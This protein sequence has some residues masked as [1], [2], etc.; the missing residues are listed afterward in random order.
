DPHAAGA[1]QLGPAT[2]ERHSRVERQHVE[3][4]LLPKLPYHGSFTRERQFPHALRRI[5]RGT[6]EARAGLVVTSG[7]LDKQLRGNAADVDAGA[8]H[9]LAALDD[10]YARAELVAA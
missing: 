10:G 4:L 7:R 3:V 6:W 1:K 2:Q 9:L 5:G 8:A